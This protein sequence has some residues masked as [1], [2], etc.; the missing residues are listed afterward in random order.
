MAN[1]PAASTELLKLARSPWLAGAQVGFIEYLLPERFVGRL[2]MLSRVA[3][4]FLFCAL[5]GGCIFS[6]LAAYWP[7]DTQHFWLAL[8]LAA[9]ACV[10]LTLRPMGA[11]YKRLPSLAPNRRWLWQIVAGLLPMLACVM[12][13]LLSGYIIQTIDPTFV[14]LM[15]LKGNRMIFFPL[16]IGWIAA[17]VGAKKGIESAFGPHSAR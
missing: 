4:E 3:L 12:V 2:G 5:L 17:S 13:A 1:L 16:V 11:V 9:M 6:L 10:L 7:A 8:Q 15:M 14:N